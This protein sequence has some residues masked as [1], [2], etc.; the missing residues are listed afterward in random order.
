MQRTTITD[1]APAG[2]HVLLKKFLATS[3]STLVAIGLAELMVRLLCSPS[4]LLLTPV[5]PDPVL[6]HRIASHVGGH[7]AN[8]FR[9]RS[10]PRHAPIVA[11]GDSQTYG[12]SA[13]ERQ[14]WPAQLASMCGLPVYNMGLGGYCPLDY[15]HLVRTLV[16][17]LS[18]K[19]VVVG[20]YFGNDFLECYDAVYVQGRYRDFLT[21]EPSPVS[22][23]PHRSDDATGKPRFFTRTRTW[24][25]RNSMLY[26]IMK[27]RL[28]D[29][30]LTWESRASAT[31]STE[32]TILQWH[33]PSRPNIRTD[34][35]PQRRLATVDTEQPAVI[36]GLRLTR[37]ALLQIASDL[38]ATE[39][40]MLVVLIPTKELVY[41]PLVTGQA[42]RIPD[43]LRRIWLHER[44]L[45]ES[46]TLFLSEQ[47]IECV[48]TLDALQD[49][50]REGTQVYPRGHDGHP[51]REGYRV[52]AEVVDDSDAVRS[53]AGEPA[54]HGK[55]IE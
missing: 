8:G 1:V 43:P 14:S 3:L 31:P 22:A 18:P 20:L 7:D 5:V 13:M 38:E 16:P 39:C 27:S 51:M 49:A 19:L 36:A 23:V 15:A 41:E 45:R 53:L 34:F 25:A 52:I 46:V 44:Q 28:R 37:E 24:L 12:T 30:F 9:N 54:M 33:D 6:G 29:T 11:V 48:D 2:K 42:E 17:S 55:D 35:T 32:D 50:V 47:G 4:D 21:G 10:V 40:R 26:G